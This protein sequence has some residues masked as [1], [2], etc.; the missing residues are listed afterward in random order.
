MSFSLALTGELEDMEASSLGETGLPE[1]KAVPF[2]WLPHP[3]DR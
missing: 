2:S 3:G 1:K